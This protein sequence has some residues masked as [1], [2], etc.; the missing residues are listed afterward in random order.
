MNLLVQSVRQS[1]LL[2]LL[3]FVPVLFVAQILVP[4]Q[5][6]LLFACSI[7]A[8][9]PLARLMSFATES[10]ASKTG[11]A[12]GGLLNATLGNL[13]ELIISL[14]ALKAGQYVLVKASLAGAIVSNTLFLMGACFLLGGLKYPMQAFNLANVRLMISMIFLATFALMVPSAIT[15]ADS[16]AVTQKLSLGISVVLIVTYALGLLFT[17]GTHRQLLASAAS[18]ENPSEGQ[19]PLG[20]SLATLLASTVLVALVSDVFVETVQ[21]AAHNLGVSAAFVGFIVVALVGGAAEMTAAFSAARKDR[22]DLSV[23]IAF[24]SASQIALFIAPLLVIL[25]YFLGPSPMNLQ[26]WPGA[27]VMMFVSIMTAALVTSSGKSAWFTGVLML[28]VYLVF[29]MTLYIL[30]PAR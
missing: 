29:A 8:I 20:L 22:L 26:F 11:D 2:W 13:T 6:T 17:L 19:W 12:A 16:Q 7:L 4:E 1:P 14:S 9:I 28:M 23:T 3:V 24:G 25:S 30:P 5:H 18:E 21:E 10:V 15:A 27:V